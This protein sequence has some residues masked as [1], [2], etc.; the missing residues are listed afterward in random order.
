MPAI[1]VGVAVYVE[2]G[3]DSDN[4]GGVGRPPAADGF[5]EAAITVA[6]FDS[7]S[8]SV[9]SMWTDSMW[10]KWNPNWHS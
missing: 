6:A 7:A 3:E 9:Q 1:P 4:A 8:F 5:D 2:V 10:S